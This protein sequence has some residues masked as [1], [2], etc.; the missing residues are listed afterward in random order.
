MIILS[1][2]GNPGREY[3][4]TRHNLGFEVIDRLHKNYGFPDFKK[5]FDGLFAKCNILGK[6]VAIFKPQSFMNISGTPIKKISQFFK[7]NYQ[8]N[9]YII[10]D[11]LDMEFLKVRI[12]KTGGHGGHNGIRDI[13]K[14]IGNDFN[15][16]KIGIKNNL[17][18]EK[19]ILPS[20]FVLTK[21]SKSEVKS[22]CEFKSIFSK[23][24]NL[25][26]NKKLS[27]LINNLNI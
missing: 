11:D 13:I 26:L 18:I 19:N 4:G 23:N 12:K 15:R 10:H 7:I 9:L 22:F 8:E 2:L 1:G 3:D 17:L 14:N 24:L 27:L 6:E 5:K 20:D 25:I 16:I 21:F